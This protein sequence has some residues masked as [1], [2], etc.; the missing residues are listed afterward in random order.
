MNNERCNSYIQSD[1][2]GS[3]QSGSKETSE[4]AYAMSPY[5]DGPEIS[6]IGSDYAGQGHSDRIEHT[7]ATADPRA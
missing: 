2:Q 4:T 7:S 1:L 6:G 5:F 3:W